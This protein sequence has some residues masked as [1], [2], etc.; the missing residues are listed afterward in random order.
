[1]RRQQ[2]LSL[3]ELLI[4]LVVGLF[5][6][7]ATFSVL[8]MSSAS[9]QSTGQFNQLQESA[10]LALR[11][12]EE[13]V[14]QSGFFSDLSGVDL[15]TGTN[16]MVPAAITGT[17]CVGAGLNNG[18]F[19]N[20]VGNFRTLWAATKGAKPVISCESGAVPGSDVLQ[21]KRLEG[22]PLS[23]RRLQI[24][25]MPSLISTKSR[26][27]PATRP[28]PATRGRIYEYQHRVYYVANNEVGSRPCFAMLW[29]AV[30]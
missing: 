27:L 30:T 25:T 5:I 4:A 7:S 17:D 16:A 22:A 19:P 20:G 21:V 1:M 15:I 14:A 11:V 6:T 29:R 12:I 9:V 3:T 13:D 8:E 18:S 28:P 2:G 26:F 10:R 23:G 24:A